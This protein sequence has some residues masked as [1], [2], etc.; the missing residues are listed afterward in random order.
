[1]NEATSEVLADNHNN[2]WDRADLIAV[3][4]AFFFPTIVTLVYF[5]W[6][7]EAPTWVQQLAMGGGKF[8]QFGFP[9]TWIW[10][11]HR[12]KFKRQPHPGGSAGLKEDIWLG[13]VFGVFVIV[14]MCTVFFLFISPTATGQ[15]MVSMV[16]EKVEDVGIASPIK[17]IAL[18]IAYALFHTFLEEYYWRW[19]V[20]DV[21]GKFVAIPL[22]NVLSSIGFSLHHVVVLAVYFGWDNPWTYFISAC[23]GIG[24]AFWAWQFTRSRTLLV[25]WISHAIVDAGIFTLGYFLIQDVIT[26][27]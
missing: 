9:V 4:F 22:A 26:K 3:A 1:M 24:G 2:P 19:F 21:L 10:F 7:E 20:Y 11:R 16:V 17:F 15:T 6:L 14:A 5:E 13:I 27:T 23:V 25:P 8:L 12:N 18:S